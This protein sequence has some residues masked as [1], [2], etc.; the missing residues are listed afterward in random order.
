MTD[1][2]V[3]HSTPVTPLFVIFVAPVED[4]G[5]AIQSETRVCLMVWSAPTWTHGVI[6]EH[7]LCAGE[8]LNSVELVSAIAQE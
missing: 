4:L 2:T 1:C 5:D 7:I 3:V 6:Q 8:Q